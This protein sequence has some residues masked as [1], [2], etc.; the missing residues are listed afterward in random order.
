MSRVVFVLFKKQLTITVD[1]CLV[2]KRQKCNEISQITIVI[3]NLCRKHAIGLLLSLSQIY[4]HESIDIGVC[5][6]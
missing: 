1:V 5:Y 4:Y 6:S 2:D 3:V